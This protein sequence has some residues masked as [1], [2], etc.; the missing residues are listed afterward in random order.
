MSGSLSVLAAPLFDPGAGRI[1]L[2]LPPGLTVAEIVGLSLPDLPE[3]ERRQL[4][5]ALVTPM[6]S[7][8]LPVQLWHRVR[9]RPGVQV[10]IRVIPGKG[11]L[12]SVLMI[13]VTVASIAMGNVWGPMLANSI[14][15]S[16]QVGIALVTAGVNVV[17]SLL[18]NALV[19]P[20]QPDEDRR[21]DRFTIS[22]WKNRHDPGGA[23]PVVLGTHRY[24]PPFAATSWSEIVGD[25]QYVRAAFAFGYGR[26]ALSDFRLGETPIGEYDEV[27]IEVREGSDGDAPLS[28]YPRQVIEESISAELTRPMPRDDAGNIIDTDASVETPVV[29]TTADDAERV[30]IILAWP[31]GLIYVDDDGD[32]R[33]EE[34]RIRIEQRLVTASAWQL[35]ET[36]TVRARKAEAFY[37][38][39]SWKLPSRGR[40]QIRLTMLT[41]EPA[42]MGRQRRTVWVALQSIRPEYP[43]NMGGQ[44]LVALRIKATH[45]LSGQLDDFSAVARRI[46]L[47][48]D[49]A[50]GT[51]VER[52]TSNPASLYRHVLQS[53]ANPRPVGDMGIDIAQ[54]ED[55]HEFCRTKSLR[56][57]RVL[58]DPG[59]KLRDV[60]A[61]IA[62]A[63]RATPR[64]DGMR[65][66]VTID[67][68]QELVVDH[69][70]P[71]NS[72]AFKAS[73]SYVRPPHAFRVRF[74]DAAA[75][76]APRERLIR[77]PGYTGEITLTEELELPGKTD[78]AEVWREGRR[79]MLE[80][81]HR[82]DMF[83]A[84]QDGPVRVATRGDLIALSQ[85]VLTD[86]QRAARVVAVSGREIALD[87]EVPV[88]A[89]ASHAIRFRSF[90]AGDTVGT[91]QIRAVSAEA[92]WQHLL[93]VDGTGSM[94]AVG[95]QVLFGQAGRESYPVVVTGVE[96]GEDMTCLVRAVAAAPQIDE[97]LDATAI[98][99]WSSR[100]GAELAQA[101][102]Q[103]P[104]P[105]F[106]GVA[107]GAAGTGERQAVEITLAPGTGTVPTA[108][109]ALRHRIAGA[110]EWN[111]TYAPAADGGF[112]LT[113]YT[114]GT[115]VQLQAAALS[116][117]GAIGQW[118]PVL[119][120]TVGS[121]DAPLPGP[122]SAADVAV[123]ALYGGVQ[124]AFETGEDTEVSA[125]QVYH[126]RT[127]LLDRTRDAATRLSVTPSRR[128]TVTLG[129]A[130]RRNLLAAPDLSDPAPWN[131]SGGWTIA[132]GVAAHTAGAAG[133]VAQAISLSPGKWY[134]VGYKLL[135]VS[136]GSVTPR[137]TGGSTRPGTA[138]ATSGDKRDRI[139]AVSG[140]AAV[141][142][143]ATSDFLG[144]LDD[145]VLY[146]ETS[147][148]LAQGVHH[149]WL[150]PVNRDGIP[151]P[152]AGPF[153]VTIT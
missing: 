83:E 47:D 119:A 152:V 37:R 126:S 35:V 8:I 137:L 22:G 91:S 13:A 71:R 141:S 38:Q 139:Q 107:T 63:G 144:Q 66:G 26:L 75:D 28:L 138:A 117:D 132:G 123:T 5:V 134:R 150:E 54:L 151:G 31:G 142:W 100:V 56:Y 104:A 143:A 148:C 94:P 106:A 24:A 55:W 127:A 115:A 67:R 111:T 1:E 4:R 14:G 19:P 112:R 93:T 109:Y 88:Q 113:T 74:N 105:R 85:D 80:A 97:L 103:P 25:W 51:W 20:P 86:A 133:A 65:W 33:S 7:D 62:A 40:W 116:V 69:L 82:P 59:L 34:V 89:G 128:W 9:P 41:E 50:S 110:A 140:N 129:D 11:G 3:I 125:V 2:E 99:S 6:G 42:N 61:E 153:S 146:Q 58:D 135:G 102:L 18:V 101:S 52:A 43:I 114:T 149:L 145:V 124:V 15:V 96:M 29:R 48:Y 27:E 16:S 122:L 57:D 77:W 17:G 95:D 118:T 68:P 32:K 36:L 87:E 147:T 79:R 49:H 39:H 44:A 108:R 53:P 81:I 136:G 78:A 73:R 12:R 90:G 30:G 121:G 131:T 84:M 98:P 60:L 21:R 130:T 92:G 46:C 64:H 23:V 120:L 76:Y 45:Q 70:T 10:V 72:W